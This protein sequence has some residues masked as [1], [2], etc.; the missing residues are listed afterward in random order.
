MIVIFGAAIVCPVALLVA[1]TA[2]PTPAGLALVG[3]WEGHNVSKGGIGNVF[4][5]R[6]DGSFV[7]TVTVIVNL[8]YAISGDQLMIANPG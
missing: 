2:C 6:A 4:E 1:A 3:K 7:Q 5:F 8:N